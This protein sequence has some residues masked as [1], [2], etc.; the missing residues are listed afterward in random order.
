MIKVIGIPYDGNSSF[1]TGPALAPPRIRLM[2]SDGSANSFSEY[3]REIIKGKNYSDMGDMSFDNS[4]P[5]E[6]YQKIK[7]RMLQELKPGAKMLCLGEI[8]PFRFPL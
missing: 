7:N 3:G 2:E 6:A 4:N 1:L 8:I 5:E